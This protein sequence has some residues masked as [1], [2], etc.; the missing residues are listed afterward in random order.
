MRLLL[1]TCP[2]NCDYTCQHVITEA[3]QRREPLEARPVVQYHGKWPFRRFL[4]MQEPFSVL[5]SLLNFLAHRDGLERVRR[6][7]PA[8]YPL[9]PYYVLLSYFGLTSWVFSM[10]FHTRDFNVT[11]KL[12]Y[13]AA[14]ASVFYGL[15]Y[16]PV[17]VFR[18]D[19]RAPGRRAARRAW[20]LLCAALFAAHVAYLTLWRWDYGYNMAANVGAGVAQNALWTA[21]SVREFRRRRRPW[22]AWPGLIV[23]WVVLAMSLELLDFPPLAGLLDAHSLWHLGTVAPTVW[24]YKYVMGPANRTRVTLLIGRACPLASLSRMHRKTPMMRV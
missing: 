15:F 16:T 12:D 9:R 11:E 10:I 22:T 18:L 17:R 14:G 23:A 3:R 20:T 4:G 2:A 8:D 13:V 24:W 21:W 1:W 7:I 6:R 5:F 19:R